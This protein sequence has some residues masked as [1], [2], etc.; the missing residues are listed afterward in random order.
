VFFVKNVKSKTLTDDE[1]SLPPAP[2]ENAFSRLEATYRTLRTFLP[3]TAPLTHQQFVD[4]YK[5]RKKG[6]YERALAELRT[7]NH[8]VAED[9]EIKVFIKLEKT[10][11]TTKADP[12]PRVISPRNPRYNIRVGR[13]LKPLEERIFKSL[14]RLFGHKTVMKGMDVRDTARVMREKWDMFRDPVAIGL[15]ASRFDQHVSRAALEFEHQIYY[16]CY[17]RKVHK[18]KLKK[19]LSYQ[20]INKCTGYAEDGVLKY[21]KEGT[22]MSGDMNTSLGNCVLMCTMIHAY[23]LH[24][25]VNGQLANN[26]DDCV[27]FI[28]RHDLPKF[29]EGLFDWFWDMGFNMQI[30]KPVFEFEQVEFCQCKPVFD[31]VV[32]RMCRN[33]VSALAKDSVLLHPNATE[34]YFRLWLNAIGLGGIAISGGMPIFQSFYQMCVRNGITSYVSKQNSKTKTMA[35][36]VELLPFYMRET[37][38]KGR[39]TVSPVT[40]ECRASFWAAYGTTPDEQI[41]LEKYY[42]GMSIGGYGDAWVP[43]AIFTEIED[44]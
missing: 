1:F 16:D 6:V 36:A 33:P 39:E 29:S 2:I 14:G 13:Y 37:G 20:L 19:L 40:P 43:R 11:R 15:D 25:G 3:S 5:G 42:D 17:K 9:A 23:L 38:M 7:G 4:G 24:R 27:V 28:E 32:W 21:V 41:C 22:R 8:S 31:G 12:V 30:E 35:D 10:D 34:N 44:C 26:G 18:D